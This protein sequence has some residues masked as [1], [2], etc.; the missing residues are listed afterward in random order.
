MII[1]VSCKLNIDGKLAV[2]KKKLAIIANCILSIAN[3]IVVA[4]SR[5]INTYL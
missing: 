3:F 5:Y 2:G 1:L 4:F